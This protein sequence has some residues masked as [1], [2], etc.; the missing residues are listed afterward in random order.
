MF[1][2]NINEDWEAHHMW[3]I[4]TERKHPTLFSC[5]EFQKSSKTMGQSPNANAIFSF[6]M[7]LQKDTEVAIT[8]HFCF[9][10]NSGKSKSEKNHMPKKAQHHSKS[11]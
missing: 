3:H 11:P 6:I 8:S 10:I 5:F 9:K 2:G 4:A 1:G 7:W